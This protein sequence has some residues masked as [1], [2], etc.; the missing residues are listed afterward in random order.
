[1]DDLT[2]PAIRKHKAKNAAYGAL[3]SNNLY[4]DECCEILEDLLVYFRRLRDQG[5]IKEKDTL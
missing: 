5:E 4:F 1:M 3:L 2:I